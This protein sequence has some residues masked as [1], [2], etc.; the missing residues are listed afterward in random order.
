LQADD[1]AVIMSLMIFHR[2]LG[3]LLAAASVAWLSAPACASP[4]D[5]F[6]DGFDEDSLGPEWGVD[7]VGG[8][9]VYVQDSHC[10]MVSPG[11]PCCV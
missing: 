6:F 4:G 7:V 5:A 2:L 9:Q 8:W 11:G 3:T 10:W 1:N